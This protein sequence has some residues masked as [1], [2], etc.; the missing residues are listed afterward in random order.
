MKPPFLL[1]MLAAACCAQVLDNQTSGMTCYRGQKY[2][3][4]LQRFCEIRD[5]TVASVGR[6][7]VDPGKNGG[8]TIKGWLRNDVS[9]RTRVETYASSDDQAQAMAALVR[10]DSSAGEVKA[11]GPE[12]QRDSWW[13]VSYEIFVPQT[14]DLN[15]MALN[16]GINVSDVRGRIEFETKN[17]GVRLVRVGGNV[18][19]QTLNGGV[20]VDL[21]G[22]TWQGEQLDVQTKNGGVSLNVPSNYSAHIQTSTV[23]GGVDSDFPIGLTVQGRIRPTNLD[24]NVGSGGPL[25][26]VTTTNGGVKLRRI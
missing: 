11:S 21:A 4:G 24:F 20:N 23:N 9:I 16:G 17:G 22:N 15:L 12:S 7:T 25:I 18:T 14:M 10:V 3:G 2:F 13:S 6:L 19:G 1:L 26:R 5:Q 8:V